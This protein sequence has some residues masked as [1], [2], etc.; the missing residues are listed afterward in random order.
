MSLLSVRDLTTE[1]ATDGRRARVVDGVSF[2]LAAGE[3]LGLVGESGCGKSTTG[4]SLLR[5]LPPNARIAAGEVWLDGE[6][7]LRKTDE[8]MRRIRGSRIAMVFQDPMTS[9]DPAFPVGDQIA[10]VLEEHRGMGRAEATAE[11]VRLL[12]LVGIPSAEARLRSYP[13]EFSGGM[14]QRIVIAITLACDPQVLIADEPT[15]AL[16]VTIQAQILRL[17]RALNTERRQ[18]GILLITHDLGVVAQLCHRVAVMYAGE[19]VETGEIEAIFTQPAHPYTQALL[20]FLPAR[21]RGRGDLPAIEGAVP[22]PFAYPGGC[23]FHPRCGRAFADC[24]EVHPPP[25]PI[26]PGHS[27]SC[28]LHRHA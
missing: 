15:T 8:E 28:L 26:A 11:A 19:I 5:L 17:L 10:E 20:G 4:F 25:F 13:H 18:T 6:D 3:I 1:F 21:A 22:N 16:D 27:A 24:A 12:R 7:L 23:R 2:D 9:L 14:R